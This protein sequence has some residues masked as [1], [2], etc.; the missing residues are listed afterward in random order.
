M[1][2]LNIHGSRYVKVVLTLVFSGTLLLGMPANSEGGAADIG[3]PVLTLKEVAQLLQIKPNIVARL[4]R[5]HKI[6][7]RLVGGYWRFNR[8]AIMEWLRGDFL[9]EYGKQTQKPRRNEEGSSRLP[10]FEKSVPLMKKSS[11]QIPSDSSIAQIELLKIAGRGTKPSGSGEAQNGEAIGEKPELSTAEEVFLR[12]QQVL[13]KPKQ[14]T[15]EFG[16]FYTK[17]E[18]DGLV[19]IPRADLGIFSQITSTQTDQD[20][21]TA[22]YTGRYGLADDLQLSASIPLVHRITDATSTS[23]LVP[24]GISQNQASAT[25]LTE[26]GSLDLGL[27]YTLVREGFGYP[28]VIV[29]LDTIIPT[30]HSSYGLATGVALIKRFDPG[31]LFANFN[32]QRTFSREFLDTTRLQPENTF[33]TAFGYA[34]SMNDTLAISNSVTGVFTT[35]TTFDNPALPSLPAQELISL[36]LALT[37]LITEKLYAEPS[38]SFAL[39]G[40]SN[41][42]MGVNFPYTFTIPAWETWFGTSD[43]SKPA[44]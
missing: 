34:L 16:L 42:T 14:L 28:D 5:Q 44:T 15:L 12:Q 23:T 21:F 22:V 20:V 4:A 2:V 32:Y 26:F 10:A 11:P 41:V 31:A 3:K 18:Q 29:N 35:R 24:L 27:R 17:A 8:R 43:S 6:P 13:L 36:R 9:H 37:A 7:A 33:T 39:N 19:V 25:S 40:P 38:V 1:I 30:R